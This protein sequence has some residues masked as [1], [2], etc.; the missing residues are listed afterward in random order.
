VRIFGD[1]TKPSKAVDVF[2]FSR[3]PGAVA[4]PMEVFRRLDI[5]DPEL[6]ALVAQV[7]ERS[8]TRPLPPHVRDFLVSLKARAEG[9]D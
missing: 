1:W 4:S 2:D 3:N 5:K 6:A 9:K 7:L 8:E